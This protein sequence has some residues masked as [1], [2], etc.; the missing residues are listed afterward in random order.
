M[1]STTHISHYVYEQIFPK[2][3]SP[4]SSHYVYLQHYYYLTALSGCVQFITFIWFSRSQKFPKGLIS[5][6]TFLHRS[7]RKCDECVECVLMC[8]C[9]K[10][11]VCF[12][13]HTLPALSHLCTTLDPPT[14]QLRCVVMVSIFSNTC[15]QN[16]H[17]KKTHPHNVH[18]KE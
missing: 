16:K 5:A 3:I 12:H 11:L 8:V 15:Q 13:F 2:V 18:C 1:Y 9:V 17:E 7:G 10:T 6:Y 14:F 4:T